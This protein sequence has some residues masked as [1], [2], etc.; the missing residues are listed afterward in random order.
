MW[1]SIGG[2]GTATPRCPHH[3]PRGSTT[4]L[5]KDPRVLKGAADACPGRKITFPPSEKVQGIFC[6]TGTSQLAACLCSAAPA[7]CWFENTS[8]QVQRETKPGRARLGLVG[9][10]ER[11]ERSGEGSHPGGKGAQLGSTSRGHC[12]PW[13]RELQREEAAG[14]ETI[15]ST[16]GR[17]GFR[18]TC[19]SGEPSRSLLSR[20]CHSHI[21]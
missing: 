18:V 19:S 13:D 15:R 3:V 9:S 11:A 6:G 2:W 10:R 7:R 14:Q 16:G 1:D 21:S 8:R 20:G 17:S 4:V 12:L 5:L